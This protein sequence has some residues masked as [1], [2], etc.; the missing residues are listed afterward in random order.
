[1]VSQYKDMHAK[2]GRYRKGTEVILKE[3]L[4]A[5]SEIISKKQ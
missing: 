3:I 5:D 1:M 2:D 4:V